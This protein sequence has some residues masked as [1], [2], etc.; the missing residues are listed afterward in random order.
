MVNLSFWCV[1]VCKKMG[2]SVIIIRDINYRYN[3]AKKEMKNCYDCE[4]KFSEEIQIEFNSFLC[5][6]VVI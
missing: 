3:I 5:G 2:I 4:I 1:G 6:S